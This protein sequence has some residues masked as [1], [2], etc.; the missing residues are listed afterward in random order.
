MQSSPACMLA[1][2]REGGNIAP[3]G[4]RGRA[5]A[6]VRVEITVSKKGLAELVRYP[7]VMTLGVNMLAAFCRLG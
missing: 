6:R 1:H 2:A 5:Q 4:R 7:S 3:V